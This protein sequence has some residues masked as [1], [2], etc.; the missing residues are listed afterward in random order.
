MKRNK[1]RLKNN[2]QQQTQYKATSVSFKVQPRH[3][4]IHQC[5]SPPEHRHVWACAHITLDS[6][7]IGELNWWWS[8]F[9]TLQEL[10]LWIYLKY[11]LLI[12]SVNYLPRKRWH[13]GKKW[14]KC[15]PVRLGLGWTV[16]TWITWRGVF[17]TAQPRLG[18]II[19][20][21]TT[22]STVICSL[23]ASGVAAASWHTSVVLRAV[24]RTIF[25]IVAIF[26]IN[27]IKYKS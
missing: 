25:K 22:S 7:Y 27:Y 17:P 10:Q 24:N 20:H 5:K 13:W 18:N 26:I 21:V 23:V 9:S 16:E 2:K 12:K 1:Q 3:L 8:T 11:S 14:A 19:Y 15:F 6:F 4:C